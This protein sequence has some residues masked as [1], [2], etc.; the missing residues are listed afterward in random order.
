MIIAQTTDPT[1]TVVQANINGA[2]TA[3]S[4]FLGTN[5]LV[6]STAAG[7]KVKGV[8]PG[9]GYL[10]YNTATNSYS[11]TQP[12]SYALPAAT[13]DNLG[14][15]KVSAIDDTSTV[16]MQ[17]VQPT[18]SGVTNYPVH[19]NN[20]GMFFVP[21]VDVSTATT[22]T[23]G[24][25]KLGSDT[26]QTATRA[27]VGA[28]NGRTYPIQVDNNGQ[29][30]VNVP[31]TDNN[32][33]YSAD[34]TYV[35]VSSNQF[36]LAAA[37]KTLIDNAIQPEDFGDTVDDNGYY[38]HAITNYVGDNKYYTTDGVK[39]FISVSLSN[40]ISGSLTPNQSD[41]SAKYNAF[42][43][44]TRDAETGEMTGV[45]GAST[46]LI[47]GSGTKFYFNDFC[48]A[49]NT[50][51]N[52]HSLIVNTPD[53]DYVVSYNT[54]SDTNGFSLANGNLLTLTPIAIQ[55]SEITALF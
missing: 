55:E 14:G 7:R 2:V 31:W 28:T 13:V 37:K 53:G 46:S 26:K 9:N 4:S 5:Y 23:S 34:G 51:I 49:F 1:W 52:G 47:I 42:L 20:D 33:T 17:N 16:A 48:Y 41:A 11:W 54:P 30:V 43:Y 38:R 22:S 24:T 15:G 25:I 35:T 40:N 18:S 19:I 32:T 29:A 21:T 39:S 10:T 8:A 36:S 45:F 6:V 12:S 50:K 27:S 44:K 3:D